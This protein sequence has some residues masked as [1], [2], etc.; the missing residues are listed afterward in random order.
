MIHETNFDAVA[1]ANIDER[2]DGSP[3]VQPACGL[4]AGDQLDLGRPGNELRAKDTA[5]AAFISETRQLMQGSA[6]W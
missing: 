6:G 5:R 3:V 4:D 1:F 2:A